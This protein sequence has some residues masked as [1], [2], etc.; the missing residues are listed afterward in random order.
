M[1]STR[2][3]P[4][5]GSTPTSGMPTV[6]AKAATPKR[7]RQQRPRIR[8]AANSDN[9][10]NDDAGMAVSSG[11]IIAAARPRPSSSDESDNNNH[12]GNDG[13]EG[14]Q[15]R[16]PGNQPVQDNGPAARVSPH[17]PQSQHH[18][19]PPA[20]PQAAAAAPNQA[21][22]GDD[23]L[24]SMEWW[25][26][27]TPG[28]QRAMMKRFLVQ[29]PVAVSAPAPA[30]VVV[31]APVAPRHK[32]KVLNLEDFHGT[33]RESVEAWLATIPQEVERQAGLGGDTWTAGELYFG[34][35][36]HL[37]DAASEWLITLSETMR[38]EDKTL[39]YVVWKLRKKY[40]RRENMFRI[41]Q[42]LASRVQKGG[43]RLSD[44]A[45]NLSK[46]GFGKC[47]PAEPMWKRSSTFAEDTCGEFGEGFKVTDW[48]VAKRRYRE[49]REL[50]SDEEGAPPA[51]R[52]TSATTAINQ[53]DWSKQGISLG[54]SESPPRFDPKGNAVNSL[55]V[56]AKHDHLS[57]AALQALILA[58]GAAR[59]EAQQ[60]KVAA[61][62]QKARALEVKA[63]VTSDDTE[64]NN[65]QQLD[66]INDHQ[67][68]GHG[69]GRSYGQDGRRFGG[70]RGFGSGRGSLANYGPSSSRTIQQ[71]KAMSSC[72][73]CG[74]VG[75]WWRECRSRLAQLGDTDDQ[76]QS[77]QQQQQQRDTTPSTGNTN[78]EHPSEE[79]RRGEGRS[80]AGKRQTKRKRRWVALHEVFDDTEEE[81][82]E[83]SSPP[84][85]NSEPAGGL[86]K[87]KSEGEGAKRREK[88]R[89]VSSAVVEV[90]SKPVGTVENGENSGVQ[91]PDGIS[92]G[93]MAK[94][95]VTASDIESST[96]KPLVPAA[97][98]KQVIPLSNGQT[99]AARRRKRRSESEVAAWR[100]ILTAELRQKREERAQVLRVKVWHLIAQQRELGDLL[101][102]KQQQ[103]IAQKAA[104]IVKKLE[105]ASQ[106]ET[107]GLRKKAKPT[108]AR[109][110]SKTPDYLTEAEWLEAVARYED[111][112]PDE[113]EETGTLAEMRAA[114]RR[115]RR[116]VKRF[117]VAKRMRRLQQQ[118][119][120]RERINGG[121]PT[122]QTPTTGRKKQ[123]R[124]TYRQHGCYGDVELRDVRN[125]KKA[126]IA[127]L[128]AVGSK[129]PSS[130]PTALLKFT[131]RH[132]Q[133]VRLDSC[134]QFSVAGKELRRF[135]R[136]LTR[137]APVDIV[138]GFGGGTSRVLGVWR[139]SALRN[140]SRGLSW[141][142]C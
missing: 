5:R 128:R 103:R 101:E 3:S 76:P 96:S 68:F 80:R 116:A 134:A 53:L 108:T 111:E 42:E 49:D 120:R 43:E 66:N 106:K 123:E 33:A 89:D 115:A 91:L 10:D 84:Q 86:L 56:A 39:S 131:K 135:G 63:E 117:L 29:P 14:G 125:G 98:E 2:A 107:Q 105:T 65:N 100:G 37:K 19:Q 102:R 130:L 72:G 44:F 40:G 64:P 126:R 38:D 47:V 8:L 132:T 45:A 35:T 71:Q 77:R 20:Q 17:P 9:S 99:P 94:E 28:Q 51:K 112:A 6:R 118:R 62:K 36:A 78:A 87:G 46:I 119:E 59:E 52:R 95:P 24:E 73:Y 136:C 70:G 85:G 55:E 83:S 54:S 67:N 82:A 11:V 16:V 109:S 58:S 93:V 23:E 13:G 81:N 140:T 88:A 31:N 121:K 27:L 7:T 25:D 133:E 30:P 90:D 22:Q 142:H 141:M 34:L 61:G 92:T 124:Y 41:Q 79:E 1:V 50:G 97:V 75:H 114:R 48:R 127:P 137:E 57:V 139:L 12:G 113:L 129:D 138:E 32:M 60:S 4:H 69:S 21:E 104:V 18:A 26:H 74:K 15:Q 110:T 122:P